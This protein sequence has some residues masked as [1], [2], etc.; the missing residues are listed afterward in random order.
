MK[1]FLALF[2]GLTLPLS[3]ITQ[4]ISIA[5][6]GDILLHKPLQKHGIKHGFA[7]MWQQVTPIIQQ[8][9]IAYANLE[10]PVDATR[11]PSSFPQFNYPKQLIPAL[12]QSGF[13]I[14][15]TANNHSLDKFS[16]GVDRTIDELKAHDLAHT[17]THKKEEV[18]QWYR[19]TSAQGV[20]VAWLAC[21][22][23]TNGIKD[24]HQQVLFCYKDKTLIDKLLADLAKRYDA[25]ILTPHWGNQ[26]QI[27]PS[28]RQR[29]FATRWLNAGA[30][31]IIG[32]HPHCLQPIKR[33][34][35][36]DGREGLVAYSMGNFVSNQ[37]SLKNRASGILWLNLTRENNKVHISA[38]KFIPTE[39]KNRGGHMQLTLL[40]NKKA[41]AYRYIKRIIKPQ[42][43]TDK[44]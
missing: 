16:Q 3:G 35:T 34:T 28:R 42:Y 32:S 2:I 12:K 40:N 26:Y 30:T 14:V 24:K 17:G 1:K 29:L 31:A 33:I 9:D 27:K 36:E 8:A 23:D 22:Q 19:V 39:M 44:P 13:S 38:V 18:R 43:L 25:V 10:G 7:S 20:R 15:S 6:V 37:G 11:K 4:T 5:A 21:T 41:L